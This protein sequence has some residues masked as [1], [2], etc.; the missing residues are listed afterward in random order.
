MKQVE[1]S[2]TKVFNNNKKFQKPT[3]IDSVVFDK[4]IRL[5]VENGVAMCCW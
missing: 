3:K 2:V 4:E 5:Y 1:R